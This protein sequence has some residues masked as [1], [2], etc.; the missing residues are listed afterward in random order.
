MACYNLQVKIGV[1]LEKCIFASE[2]VVRYV[3][4]Y[5]VKEKLV[6]QK[7]AVKTIMSIP[8]SEVM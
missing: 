4:I 3:L 8:V 2:N 7:P 5:S 6:L 1:K